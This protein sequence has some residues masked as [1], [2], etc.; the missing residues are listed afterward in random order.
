MIEDEWSAQRG[1]PERVIWRDELQQRLGAQGVCG[2]TMSRY[3]AAGKLP[4]PDIRLSA[5]RMGWKV[6]TLIKAGLEAVC[7]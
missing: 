6:S 7:Y 5:K 2:K 3:I 4:A 1:G